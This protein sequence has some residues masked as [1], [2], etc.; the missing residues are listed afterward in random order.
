MYYIDIHNHI[1]YGVDDGA[2]SPQTTAKMLQIA[3]EDGIR[4]IIC[5]PHYLAGKYETTQQEREL[6]IKHL[7]GVS[8]KFY[9]GLQLYAGCEYFPSSA[10]IVDEVEQ[11]HCGTLAGSKYLLTEFSPETPGY[12]IEQRLLE[13]ISGGFWPIV[14]HA[15]RYSAFENADFSVHIASFCYI[16]V[17]ANS[18]LGVA[19]T[20]EKKIAKRMLNDHIVSFVASDAHGTHQRKPVLSECAKYIESHY[21]TAYMEELFYKNPKSI[22]DN[23]RI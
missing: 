8:E 17:N 13:M 1:L 15:E 20:K 16:Q 18:V 14:A 4:A 21:G 2:R 11:G 6:R 12:W 3:Y 23:I 19:G 22:I 5:T 7:R 9:P 10:N